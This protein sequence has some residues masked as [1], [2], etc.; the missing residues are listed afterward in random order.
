MR[1]VLLFITITYGIGIF[2]GA[3]V[4]LSP[5][6]LLSLLSTIL[7]IAILFY[8]KGRKVNC[9]LYLA[10][11]CFGIFIS[12]YKLYSYI[13]Q[14]NRFTAERIIINGQITS[15]VK[16]EENMNIFIMDVDS[17]EF[18][19]NIYPCS[20]RMKIIDYKNKD[21]YIIPFNSVRLSGIFENQPLYKNNYLLYYDRFMLKDGVDGIFTV[22]YNSNIESQNCTQRYISKIAFNTKTRIER[23]I[24]KYVDSKSSPIMKGVLLGDTASIEE[25]DFELYKKS[26]IVHIFAVSGYNILLIYYILSMM[27]SFLKKHPYLKTFIIIGV[28]GFYTVMTGA[29]SSIIRAFVMADVLLI[30][31][32]INR[33][34]D[35]LTSLAFAALIILTVNPFELLNI[36]FQLSFISVLCIILL[37]PKLSKIKLPINEK[38]KNL[39]MVPLSVQIGIMPILIL[40]F[41]NLSTL[42]IIINALIIPLFSIFTILGIFLCFVNLISVSLA[43]F[44]GVVVNFLG[45]AIKSIINVLGAI[46]YSNLNL[47]SLNFLEIL[48]YY[49]AIILAFKLINIREKHKKLIVYALSVL[50]LYSVIV[51]IY[52]SPLKIYFIDV[53]QGDSILICTP[54]KK[55]IL[56][57]GGG[58]PK[59]LSPN[60]DIGNDVLKPYL[61]KR[62]IDKIDVMISTHSDDDHLAGLI[63]I[64]Q[65]FDVNMFIKSSFC[66]QDNYKSIYEDNTL[67]P[68]DIIDISKGDI[69]EVGKFVKLYVINPGEKYQDENDSSIVVKL[70]YKDFSMLLTGDISSNVE[71]NMSKDA[72]VSDILKVPHHGSSYSLDLDFLDSV[73]PLAAVIC[74]GKNNFGH[75]SGSVIDAIEERKIE[76]FRTD[77]NGEIVIT[78]RGKGFWV[79]TAI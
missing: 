42:S 43:S 51:E 3:A 73:H 6:I 33:K 13:N 64:M 31:K 52:P 29:S 11:I 61:L 16:N 34:S 28:L 79:E 37:L 58:R 10:L 44:T 35:H 74:V 62:R 20:L 12:S 7:L 71:K 14:T 54:D 15:G 4:K 8:L 53:G 41:N 22:D 70:V 50:F 67:R 25:E 45:N 36:G 21:N 1:R 17:I 47:I 18:D 23:I 40:N 66:S 68:E 46:P 77:I 63:P 19:N 26:G 59:T 30:G 78:T 27:L 55:N 9:L 24:D 65:N 75:P 2:I 56:I 72:L 57:D 76:L 38:I 39:F 69:I 60:I 49:A 32:V 5:F 48:L